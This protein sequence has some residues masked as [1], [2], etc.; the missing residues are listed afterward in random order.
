M[1]KKKSQTPITPPTGGAAVRT[2]S[3][4]GRSPVTL[5]GGTTP[6][7]SMGGGGGT[8]NT[9]SN[10]RPFQIP[11]TIGN[12]INPYAGINSKDD[13]DFAHVLGYFNQNFANQQENRAQYLNAANQ[14]FNQVNNGPLF[15]SLSSGVQGAMSPVIDQNMLSALQSA[16][17]DRVARE[18]ATLQDAL[19][20]QLAAQGQH[21][22][23]F[24]PAFAGAAYNTAYQTGQSDINQFMNA[25]QINH[26][27]L[28]GAL[29]A[30]SNLYGLQGN[31]MG[32]FLDTLQKFAA[33]D[34]DAGNL[35]V[36]LLGAKIA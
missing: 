25:Q 27:G 5:G 34:Q 36:A 16:G 9:N 4:M 29:G 23:M 22:G 1:A 10:Y 33:G 15:N 19:R 14:T 21:P 35:L 8:L 30:G 24:N 26:Q 31:Q 17:R 2:N 3:N 12:Q 18:G 20:T 6:G 28:L 32:M 7:S 11:N 13:L